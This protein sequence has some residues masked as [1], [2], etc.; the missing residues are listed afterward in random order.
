MAKSARSQPMSPHPESKHRFRLTRKEWAT[1]LLG[2]ALALGSYKAEDPW[3]ALPMLCIAGA[4]FVMFCC[5]HEGN[6]AS[7]VLVAAGLVCLLA[8]IAWRDLQPTTQ[9]GGANQTRGRPQGATT[10]TQSAANSDCSNLV[11]GSDA[12]INCEAEKE[13]HAKDKTN[14]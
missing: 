9:I 8:F 5:W 10:I 3:V 11:A 14:R 13:Q 6:P 1:L 7:R 2:T 12:K 4:A